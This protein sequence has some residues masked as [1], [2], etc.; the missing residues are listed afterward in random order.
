MRMT[1]KPDSITLEDAMVIKPEVGPL[2]LRAPLRNEAPGSGVPVASQMPQLS[3]VVRV[4][5]G[6]PCGRVK[7]DGGPYI[8][9]AVA[10]GGGRMSRTAWSRS[11]SQ[12]HGT[13]VMT[14]RQDKVF[15]LKDHQGFEGQA[16]PMLWSAMLFS[17]QVWAAISVLGMQ[18]R[19]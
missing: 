5:M 14:L 16:D 8:S 3:C 11:I 4:L 13:H 1:H 2:S 19:L 18:K 10:W 9:S 7:A 17:P 6:N 15:L 12:R